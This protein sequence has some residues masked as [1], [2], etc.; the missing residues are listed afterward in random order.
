M[1][2]PLARLTLQF[3]FR[4]VAVAGLSQVAVASASAQVQPPATVAIQTL[5]MVAGRSVPLTGGSPITKVTVAN[6]LIADVVVISET[7]VVING[8]AAGETDIILWGNNVARRH[9]R[10][11][12][13]SS[14]ER[15]Q[16]L[17][18]VKFAEVRKDALRQ[19]ST[20]LLYRS[21]NGNTRVGG[22]EFRT[23]APFNEQG[24]ITLPGT[25]RYL[26]LL[27]T[28]NTNQLLSLLDAE[29]T[30]GNARFL[31]EPNLMAANREEATFLAGGEIPIPVV[32][33]G[34]AGGVAQVIVQYREFGIRLA[35]TGEVL[36][37]S[38][39]KLKLRP[40]VSTLDY[41]NAIT[42]QGF[43]IPALRTRRVE[44]T[45]DVLAGRSLIISGLFN[46]ERERV[47]TGIPFLV[48]I[49]ILGDLFSSQRWLNNES[50]LIV[51]V[52][53]IL[54]DPNNPRPADLLRFL[55]DTTL[56]AR[57][58]LQKR[59]PPDTTKRR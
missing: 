3:V 4:T 18:S 2:N 49:P 42:L 26:T 15:R 14:P 47:K 31:A 33:G 21:N 56:P 1:P 59:L 52:T 9:Y 12:V 40:E 38:L 32:Q 7:E 45:V 39:L 30:R 50:E 20:S 17:V 13:R 35:F 34:G 53:P 10:V 54:M 24:D 16:I 55:P 44:S 23:D 8:L 58:A 46:E 36:T 11:I 57:P 19:I 22:G 48:N 37:D 6:P 5:E 51:V 28:F 43:R 27:S 25:T 41:A 29:E